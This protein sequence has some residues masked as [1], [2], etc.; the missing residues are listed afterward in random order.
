MQALAN[1]RDNDQEFHFGLKTAEKHLAQQNRSQA[2]HTLLPE[3]RGVQAAQWTPP[4]A[5]GI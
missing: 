3:G 1:C 4:P 5:L 2:S